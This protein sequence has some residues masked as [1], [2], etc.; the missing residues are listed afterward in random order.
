VAGP[1]DA[2]VH[3]AGIPMP[4]LAA[5]HRIFE[6]NTLSTYNVFS[7]CARLGVAR[8]VWASSETIMG[9]PFDIPPDFAPL[10]ETHSDRPSWSYALSKVMG[11]TMAD[12]FVRWRPDMSIVSL[13]FSNVY[14]EADYA[15]VA[16]IQTRTILRKANLWAYVDARD[17]G[18]ACRLAAE[19]APSGHHR[20][21]IAADDTIMDVPSADLLAEHFPATPVRGSLAPFGSLLSSARAAA[22]I[23][24]APRYGWRGR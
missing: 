9:L 17:C 14:D 7:A 10:D 18:E 22:L 21:I 5:D 24:Y 23:G 8:V 6:T 4:G 3:L 20:L 19:V 2:V 12:H 16:E 1:P 15:G 11:E 13:R